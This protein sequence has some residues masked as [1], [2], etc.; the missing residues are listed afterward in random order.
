MPQNH[1][2][3]FL[4]QR[5]RIRVPSSM[6]FPTPDRALHVHP[7]TILQISFSEFCVRRRWVTMRICIR[8]PRNYTRKRNSVHSSPAGV[9]TFMDFFEPC[10]TDMRIDL[11]R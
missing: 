8:E 7:P 10:R 1:A 5:A 9:G 6:D 4:G 11:C 3:P 2:T